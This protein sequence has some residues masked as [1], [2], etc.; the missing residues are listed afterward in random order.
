M[1]CLCLVYVLPTSQEASLA[2]HSAVWRS[3]LQDYLSFVEG[4]CSLIAG[5]SPGPVFDLNILD[6]KLDCVGGPRGGGSICSLEPRLSIP[7][8]VLQLCLCSFCCSCYCCFVVAVVVLL[9]V[10]FLLFLFCHSCCC[11]FVVLVVVV[12]VC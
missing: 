6:Q 10:L 4:G 5:L 12:V 7:D 11:C 1:S 3:D 8:F 2:V 9:L